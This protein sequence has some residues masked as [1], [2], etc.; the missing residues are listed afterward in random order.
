MMAP[1][2]LERTEFKAKRIVD[3]RNLYDEITNKA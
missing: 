2:S 1:G 3:E